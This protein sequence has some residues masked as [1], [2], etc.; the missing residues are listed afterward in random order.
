MDLVLLESRSHG[1]A[2]I[3]E[4]VRENYNDTRLPQLEDIVAVVT[5]IDDVLEGN[6][7]ANNS[8]SVMK[9]WNDW[10]IG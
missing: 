9:R 8:V 7:I 3:I 1:V 10:Q 6:T 2:P 4:V 5:D